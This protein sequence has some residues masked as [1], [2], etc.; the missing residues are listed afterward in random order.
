MPAHSLQHPPQP[1]SPRISLLIDSAR[2]EEAVP[3]L[4]TGMFDGVTTN[5]QLLHEAHQRLEDVASIYRWALDNGGTE[6]FF[7]TWGRTSEDLYRNAKRLREAAP[8]ATI[9]VPCTREGVSA[10]A[11]LHGDGVS[12]LLTAVYS[13]K[14]ALIASALNVKYIAPYFN[15]MNLSGRDGLGEIRRMTAII[16]QDGSGPLIVAASLKS[17]DQLVSL[18]QVGVRAF[19][20]APK[21]LEDLLTDE[22]TAGAVADFERHM[23]GVL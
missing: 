22:L 4:R 14:Q 20:A 1:H 9:K 11:Q 13:A 5:P 8:E 17:A 7:Q 2:E 3:W 6:V 23:G 12:V 10:I 16:K 18:A 15:R 21:V 19:T